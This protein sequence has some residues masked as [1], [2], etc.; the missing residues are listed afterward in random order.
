MNGD[1]L[2]HSDKSVSASVMR[3]THMQQLLT[4][5]NSTVHFLKYGN[6]NNPTEKGTQTMGKLS[7]VSNNYTIT[8]VCI[9]LNKNI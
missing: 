7:E 1:S 8:T 6:G 4:G 9:Y 2:S 3:M 5:D